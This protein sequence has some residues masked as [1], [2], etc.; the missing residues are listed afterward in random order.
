MGNVKKLLSGEIVGDND[1][2]TPK[3]SDFFRTVLSRR[4]IFTAYSALT[5]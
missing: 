4:G 2:G 3:S 1:L 5:F